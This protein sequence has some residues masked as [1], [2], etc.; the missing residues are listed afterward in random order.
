M[1]SSPKA[2]RQVPAIPQTNGQ[3]GY[4]WC[5]P[6]NAT[7]NSSSSEVPSQLPPKG[8]LY[9]KSHKASSSTCEG[10]NAAIAHHVGGR[11]FSDHVICE[12]YGRHEFANAKIH[13]RKHPSKSLLWTFVR[14][15]RTRD[16]SQVFHFRVSRQGLDPHKDT[17]ILLEALRN[18]K[19]T[20]TKYL[21]SHY[22]QE[23]FWDPQWVS[24]YPRKIRKLLDRHILDQ[25]D[26]IGLTERMTE[27]L[28]VMTL[29]WDLD[30]KD[31]IVLSAKQSHHN[32]SYDAGG[33]RHRCHKLQ[34]PTADN[35][36]VALS[37]YLNSSDY[38]RG[39]A[40][41]LLYHEVQAKLDHTIQGLGASLV[42][43]RAARI[44]HLQA[45]A[46]QVCRPTAIFP[47]S[48]TGVYQG[49]KAQA[50]CYV[51]D[52]GCGYPCV[53]QLLSSNKTRTTEP[54]LA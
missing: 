11:T 1:T 42:Q 4:S 40:D 2:F 51:Q 7:T 26:F 47:C 31:V 29:L 50:N 54:P 52:A 6:T 37:N 23:T 20:Q 41:F 13:G 9:I 32:Q 38:E 16:L 35:L 44:G 43:D 48:E 36:P 28:A 10:I 25:Y 49:L 19:S 18:Q 39:H 33:N 17:E 27:S 46:E 53:D 8:L 34:A 22:I 15:P 5:L 24:Q 12:H 30:P 21:L 3:L 45:W 14:H